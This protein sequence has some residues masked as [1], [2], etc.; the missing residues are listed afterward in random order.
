MLFANSLLLFFLFSFFPPP[1]PPPALET[2]FTDP[3]NI[4]VDPDISDIVDK[5]FK[6]PITFK[7]ICHH[8]TINLGELKDKTDLGKEVTLTVEAIGISDMAMAV[9]VSGFP[10]KNEIPHITVAINPD[11]GKPVISNE[12]TKWRPIK[13][14]MIRGV[15]TEIKKS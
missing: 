5:E 7:I 2:E 4:F 3:P 1:F 8:M 15:V 9:R 6:I 13:S 12:I 11:G 14:F 10:S